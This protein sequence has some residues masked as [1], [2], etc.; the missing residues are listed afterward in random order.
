[1]TGTPMPLGPQDIYGQARFVD[2]RVFGTSHR[3]FLSQYFHTDPMYP[4]CVVGQKNQPE[5]VERLNSIMF[6]VTADEVL[7][8]PPAIHEQITVTLPPDIRA[9]YREVEQAVAVEVQGGIV[10]LTNGMVKL[11]RLQQATSSHLGTDSGVRSLEPV[12]AKARAIEDWLGDL[13][14]GEPVAIFVKFIHDLDQVRAICSRTGRV[15]AELSGREKTLAEW[16]RGERDT[17]AVQMQAGGVGVDLTRCGDRPCRYVAYMSVGFA[18]ADYEQ[19][20]ARVRRPGQTAECV[21]YYHFVVRDSIDEAVYGSLL[22]KRNVVEDVLER[23]KEVADAT[24]RQRC[25]T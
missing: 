17:I 1:M 20:L 12:S 19:S 25:G 13:A 2:D 23:L 11:L 21:R 10:N 6:R 3:A 9:T 22:K 5:F 24:T 14:P 8:L 15:Y 4:S 18:L 16:Q 7:D